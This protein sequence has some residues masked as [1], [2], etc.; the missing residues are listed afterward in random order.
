MPP[1]W[2]AALPTADSVRLREAT[3][4]I[5]SVNAWGTLT[6]PGGSY[7]VLRES[8][9]QYHELRIDA[10]IPV[11]GWLDVTD[12]STMQGGLDPELFDEDTTYSYHFINDG[13]KET[14]AIV[15]YVEDFWG[16]NPTYVSNVQYKVADFSTAAEGAAAAD[17]TVRVFPNPAMDRIQVQ[18]P[19][20][21]SGACDVLVMDAMGRQVL[22]SRG[23]PGGLGLQLDL[24]ISGLEAGMYRGS[25]VPDSGDAVP[26]RFVKS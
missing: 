17:A 8:R 16:S 18:A 7:A 9:V 21:R 13:S 15:T 24:D 11:L 26:F 19:G 3:T 14:I 23:A 1:S 20:L 6:I 4:E 10:L 2:N 12:Q 25:I 5:V 22:R